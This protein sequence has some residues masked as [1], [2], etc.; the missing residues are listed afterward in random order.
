MLAI[1]NSE[2]AMC[3]M[4]GRTIVCPQCGRRHKVRFSEPPDIQFYRCGKD[5]YL[6]GIN[7]RNIMPCLPTNHAHP[8]DRP[9]L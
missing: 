2:L 7:G 1:G 6:C 4:L 5:T 8:A 9:M 3:E